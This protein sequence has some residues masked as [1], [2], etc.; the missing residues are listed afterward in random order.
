MRPNFLIVSAAAALLAGCAGTVRNNTLS[1]F[2]PP[3]L[4]KKPVEDT[5]IIAE[6]TEGQ[7]SG[8]QL[9]DEAFSEAFDR[10]L[11]NFKSTSTIDRNRIQDRLIL[12]SNEIC[13]NY[14]TLLKKKQAHFNYWSGTAATVFGAA[15]G[16][17]T[18]TNAARILSALSGASSGV[19]AEYNEQYFSDLAAHVVTKGINAR[20]KEI[21]GVITE[22]RSKPVEVYSI[23][24]AIADAI[25]YHGVCSLVG[26]LEQADT[27]LSK[28]NSSAG[29]DALGANP[30][31]TRESEKSKASAPATSPP[32]PPADS[33]RPEGD[34]PK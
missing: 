15:G 20:R 33:P 3:D 14:K 19:R 25:V 1:K 26:G 28:F 34:A 30:W 4:F 10:A 11:R 17:A 32:N 5:D 18:G 9:T 8:K 13:E 7:S 16:V 2:G 12:A 22:A 31:F 24:M 23:E 27:T 21:L 6:L 29:L